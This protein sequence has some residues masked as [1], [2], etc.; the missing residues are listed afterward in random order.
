[1]N[2]QHQLVTKNLLQNISDIGM[3]KEQNQE[4]G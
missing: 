3:E 1:M 4:L 2:K